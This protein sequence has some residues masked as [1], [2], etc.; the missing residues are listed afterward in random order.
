MSIYNVLNLIAGLSFFLFG[1]QVMGDGLTKTAG[2]RLEYILEQLSNTRFKGLLLGLGVTAIIQSSSATTVMV[3]GFVNAG[4]M[5]LSQAVGIIMGANIGTTVTAWILSLTGLSSNSPIVAIFMPKTFVPILALIGII[6]FMFVKNDTKKDIGTILLGFS[7]LMFGMQTMSDA[8]SPLSSVPAFTSLMT[9]FS[10]PF[11]GLLVGMVITAIIQSSS[12]SVGILQALCVTGMVPYKVAIPI[13]LGQN[14]G[15]CITAV[16]SA[17]GGKTNAKRAAMI[18]VYLNVIGAFLFMAVFYGLNAF[19]HFSIMDEAANAVGIA[20]V[21]SCFN[22]FVVLV[23]FP[24]G[25]QIVKLATLTVKEKVGE[26]DEEGEKNDI[27]SLLDDRFLERPP[28]AV[29]QCETVANEMADETL[30]SLKNAT[31][32]ILNYDKK[33]Y[34]E[35]LEEESEIDTFEDVLGSYLVKVSAK[36]LSSEDGKKISIILHCISDLERISDHARNIAESCS[37]MNSGKLIFSEKCNEEISVYISAINEIVSLSVNIFKDKN[38][39]NAKRIEPL[40]EVIDNINE[41]AR[42]HHFKRLQKGKCT[43][44]LGIIYED[45][46]TD[47]ERIADHCSN[48]AVC[49]IEINNNTYDTHEYIDS[50][51][52]SQTEEFRNLC[53]EYDKKFHI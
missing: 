46:L 30:E 44:E 47:L 38:I 15:T 45:L 52:E 2:S 43:L 1:M 27:L 9:R 20:V 7:V 23:L 51:K 10:N 25:N 33:T 8:V 40:E 14:I 41:K 39:D 24:F 37:K 29:S 34:K 17:I 50:L 53:K 22:I 49:I 35:V 5:K 31:G 36:S 28:F 6:L 13:I 48:I 42:R 18:H 12:A 16:I 32:L 26:E 4:I 21:H 19:L 11:L 3:V